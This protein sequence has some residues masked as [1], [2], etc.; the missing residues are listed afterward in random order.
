VNRLRDEGNK[1]LSQNVEQINWALRRGLDES[2]RQF[3]AELSEQ[4][5]K[6]IIATRKAME[7]ALSKSESQSQQTAGKEIKLKQTLG[8]LQKILTQLK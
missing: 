3:G 7:V 2:F 4:L 5:D 6:T 1:L 8:K